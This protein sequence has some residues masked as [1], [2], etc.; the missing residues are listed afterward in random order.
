MSKSKKERQ[1]S[2]FL[3]LYVLFKMKFF[4]S[5]NVSFVKL[6]VYNL[7]IKKTQSKVLLNKAPYKQPLLWISSPFFHQGYQRVLCAEDFPEL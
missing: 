7:A 4:I 1:E 6:Y 2:F 3:V 5:I